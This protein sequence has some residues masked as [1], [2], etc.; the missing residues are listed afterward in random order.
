MIGILHR[1]RNQGSL[2]PNTG[3][4]TVFGSVELEL[5]SPKKEISRPRKLAEIYGKTKF[6]TLIFFNYLHSDPG[7]GHMDQMMHF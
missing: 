6:A 3:K 5:T 7:T 2:T 4:S 1:E